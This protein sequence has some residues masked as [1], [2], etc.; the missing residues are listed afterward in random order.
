MIER[1]SR[2]EMTKIWDLNSKFG[3]YLQVELAVC[4]A[5]AKLGTIPSEATK[6]I[7]E[8]ASFSVERIDEI[9]RGICQ[10]VSSPNGTML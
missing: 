8:K 10:A 2:E 5:Y 4:D 7:R 3:Y 1:Y 9:E 6:E